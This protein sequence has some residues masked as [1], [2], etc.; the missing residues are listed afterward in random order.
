VGL[1]SLERSAKMNPLL[2]AMLLIAGV[3]SAVEP[4]DRVPLRVPDG[5]VQ[6]DGARISFPLAHKAKSA[7]LLFKKMAGEKD[8]CV[9]RPDQASDIAGPQYK[10]K[11]GLKTILVKW[12]FIEPIDEKALDLVHSHAPA[13]YSKDDMLYVSSGGIDIG[14]VA[15]VVEGVLIV[16]VA[17]LPKKIVHK[18]ARIGW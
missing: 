18:L 3:C 5:A 12:S 2:I 4:S 17:T 6:I 14:D 16:Q 7:N 8:F 11:D 13:I 15:K 9:L 1:P 10:E